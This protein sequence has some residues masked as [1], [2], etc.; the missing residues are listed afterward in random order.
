M[1]RPARKLD[2]SAMRSTTYLTR[3]MM[4]DLIE[5]AVRLEADPEREKRIAQGHCRWCFYGGSRLGGAAMT[6]QPCAACGEDQTYNRHFTR[7]EER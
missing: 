7:V 3:R 6:S 5:R 1:N 2:L 4:D